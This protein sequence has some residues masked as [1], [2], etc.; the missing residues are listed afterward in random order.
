ALLAFA[1]I[2]AAAALTWWHWRSVDTASAPP[3]A[4][5]PASW[6]NNY[7]IER[8]QRDVYLSVLNGEKEAFPAP[9]PG[10]TRK[11]FEAFSFVLHVFRPLPYGFTRTIELTT[12]DW[13]FACLA[14]RW[15]FIYWFLWG[16]Y[17]FTR[18]FHGPAR[19]LLA[20]ILLC[21]FY[22]FSTWYYWGQLT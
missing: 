5:T 8:W 2:A 14:Y 12:G 13:H 22:P 21:C 10:S 11:T 18:L 15:F 3:R 19:A 6:Q 9:E 20:P 4:G 1:M 17:R 16:S 7:P